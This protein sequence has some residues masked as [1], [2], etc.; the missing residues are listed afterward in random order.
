VRPLALVAL[1]AAGVPLAACGPR[2]ILHGPGTIH[3]DDDDARGPGGSGPADER[4]RAGVTTDELLATSAG[5][6]GGE[7]TGVVISRLPAPH[8]EPPSPSPTPATAAG[9]RLLRGHRD[10]R[11]PVAFALT[12]AA[13]LTGAQSPA[14]ADGPVLVAW[15]REQGAWDTLPGA[16]LA[17]GDLVVLDRA[18][19]N[20]P[21]SLVAVALDTDERGVTELLYLARG[22]VRVGRVDPARPKLARDKHGRQ[23]NSYVR[24]TSDHPP[25]GTRFLTGEL[26]AG[27]IR[28]GAST[29]P[30]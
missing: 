11:P 9:A 16:P 27:R 5:G 14:F 18:V 23:V 28:L 22:V 3:G 7:P 25:A 2:A 15:A 8:R 20:T 13:S 30:R 26:L 29:P 21:A 17:A 12:I 24:H 10:P 19:E 1:L 4:R 6:V